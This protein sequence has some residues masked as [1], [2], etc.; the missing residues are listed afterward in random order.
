M[1]KSK[2][3][4]LHWNYFLAIETDLIK[5]ARYIE[6]C[7]DNLETYSIELAHILISASS[8]VD[9]ILKEIC[10][11]KGE[12]ADNINDYRVAIQKH[13][14]EFINE[15]I[16]LSRYGLEFRPWE[17]WNEDTNPDWWRSNNKVKHER[18]QHFELANLQNALNAVGALLISVTYYYQIIFNEKNKS[19]K[20]IDL[21]K[22]T[23]W[24]KPFPSLFKL[25]NE[26]YHHPVYLY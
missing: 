4:K 22:T 8:E 11:L 21:N 3:S 25:R 7:E 1:I 6:F 14:P 18:N 15:P 26:Y 23:E 2:P 13:L 10:N 12:K 16:Y 24:L 20:E 19:K 17:N 5:T 9:V